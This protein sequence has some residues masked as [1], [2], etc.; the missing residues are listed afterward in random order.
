MSD[1]YGHQVRRLESQ[2]GGMEHELHSLRTKLGEVEDLDYELSDIR[3]IEDDLSTVRNDLTEMDDDVRGGAR[4]GRKD[5]RRQLHC[6][7]R[8]EC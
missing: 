6:V 4:T 8:P 1:D 3:S 2:T 5:R 7:R